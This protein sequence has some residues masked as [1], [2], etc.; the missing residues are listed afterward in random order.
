MLSPLII[1][2]LP[3]LGWAYPSNPQMVHF[4]DFDSKIYVDGQ[5]VIPDQVTMDGEFFIGNVL[6]YDDTD[7]IYPPQDHIYGSL[8][9]CAGECYLAMK[10]V[11]NFGVADS[12]AYEFWFFRHGTN[13]IH[14]N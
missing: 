14:D 9:N 12:F 7:D 3:L 2:L 4:W 11:K 10:S 8:W 6:P 5:M 1:A 13:T